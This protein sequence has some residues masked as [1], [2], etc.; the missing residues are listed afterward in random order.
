MLSFVSVDYN[1]VIQENKMGAVYDYTTLNTML[2][3]FRYG[4]FVGNDLIHVSTL[5]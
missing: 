4:A 5:L 2:F 3:R 1:L